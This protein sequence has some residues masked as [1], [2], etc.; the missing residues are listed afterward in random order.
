MYESMSSFVSPENVR[1]H[2]EYLKDLKFKYSI[3]E[4]SEP[5]IKGACA[6]D[7]I[8]MRILKD[9]KREAVALKSEIELHKCYFNSF[10][11]TSTA[12][13]SFMPCYSSD[14]DFRYRIFCT[15]MELGSGFVYITVSPHA[16]PEIRR[17][18][19]VSV[20]AVY[21]PLF[22]L[23]VSEHAYFYDWGFAKRE[24]LKKAISALDLGRINI[25][26][27]NKR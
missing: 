19:D 8:K 6:R 15:A 22:A 17:Y 13:K 26:L 11:L 10:S 4:K 2:T 24:Y 1:M 20:D 21:D 25:I 14:A 9:I 3:L 5:K 7:I 23:D 18:T 27:D 12:L 16:Y